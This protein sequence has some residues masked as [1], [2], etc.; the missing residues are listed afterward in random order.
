MERIL[1]RGAEAIIKRVN[2]KIV[3]ERI[4]KG[5]RI[6]E[7]DK[8][9]RMQRTRIEARMIERAR[10]AG[11]DVPT[12][13]ST[14][15]FS[16]VMEYIDGER[17]RD[18]LNSMDKKEVVEICKK[19]GKIVAL[20]HENKIMHGD[21]TT[22]NMILA[23]DKIYLIDFGLAKVTNRVE[24]FATDL[25]LLYEALRSTHFRIFDLCWKNILNIY[26]Q[27]YSNACDVIKRFEII[28][29]RR[30]YK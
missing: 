2:G 17:L 28:K 9:I 12:I 3:K 8:K 4:K 6:E 10:R 19:I 15:N 29:R 16:I 14:E 24:D 25:F 5:Y 18:I 30:R 26:T 7:L 21:I 27:N 20:L 1:Q 22:S 23:G 11:V 13:Y